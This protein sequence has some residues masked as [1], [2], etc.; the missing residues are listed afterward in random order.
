MRVGIIVARI[1]LTVTVGGF[2]ID[3]AEAVSEAVLL[4]V[5]DL[6]SVGVRDAV[7]VARLP[8]YVMSN[9]VVKCEYPDTSTRALPIV[10]LGTD[11]TSWFDVLTEGITAR[12][13]T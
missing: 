8:E 3:V 1:D 11:T 9:F 5:G 6:V 7:G 12:P 13:S 4:E 10:C 2:L